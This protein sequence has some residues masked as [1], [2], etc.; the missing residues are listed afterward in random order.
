MLFIVNKINKHVLTI[1]LAKRPF[2]SDILVKFIFIKRNM[3]MNI[4]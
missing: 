1:F 2:A 4:L 3:Y